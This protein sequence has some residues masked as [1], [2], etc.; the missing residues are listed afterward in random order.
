VTPLSPADPDVLVVGGGVAGLACATRL[1]E[2]G[3]RV[4]LVEA[5]GRLGGRAAS[6]VD[7]RVGAEIDNGP[8]LLAGAYRELFSFLERIGAEPRW[9]DPVRL[10]VALWSAAPHRRHTL[11][12][13]TPGRLGL[14]L[15]FAAFGALSA[16]DSWRALAV[17]SAAPE[18]ES[19]PDRPLDDWLSSLDQD[20]EA[21]RWLWYPM[22]RAVFNEEPSILSTRLFA[23]VVRR[24]FGEGA[25][26]A[27]LLRPAVG[28]SRLYVDPATAYLAGHGAEVR[29]S[30]PVESVRGTTVD[31]RA[32][33][34]T[35]RAV[36]L[37]VPAAD[38]AR[39]LGPET[40]ASIPHLT[41]AARAEQAP[42]TS[43]HLWYE[44]AE[45]GLGESFAGFVDGDFAWAFDQG[46]VPGRA[47]RQLALVAPGSRSLADLPSHRLVRLARQALE[48]HEPPFAARTLHDARVVKEPHAAPSLTP[49]AAR[50]RPAVETAI[51]GLALAG[52][53][54]DTSLPATLE[55]AAW[56]GHR[57]AEAL[58]RHLARTP[59][60]C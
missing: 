42:L 48:A 10:R 40:A 43:V 27:A 30:W 16:N 9:R 38:A 20:T 23:I 8:H 15:G 3:R 59:A 50:T 46:T 1:C 25:Q 35:A 33:T 34:L 21:R 6:W 4:V 49:E 37:A 51:P 13:R 52:D 11:V 36:C 41:N 39:L 26:A 5:H 24:L 45:P 12:W 44:D 55:S 53:W 28:L 2:L 58:E 32:G 29:T 31:G 7:P 56:S 18:A 19:A 54:T 14:A 47:L 17:I 22:A 57:A 60:A